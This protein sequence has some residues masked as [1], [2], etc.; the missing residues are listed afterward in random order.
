MGNIYPQHKAFCIGFMVEGSTSHCNEKTNIIP[1]T[2]YENRSHWHYVNFC[3]YLFTA[4]NVYGHGFE[5]GRHSDFD[6]T[7]A[8]RPLLDVLRAGQLV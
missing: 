2:T 6:D 5:G 4:L 1:M 3:Y 7:S 8:G